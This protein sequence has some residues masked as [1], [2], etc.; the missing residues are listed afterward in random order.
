MRWPGLVMV[1]LGAFAGGSGG[2]IAVLLVG[3]AAAGWGA[4]LALPR[5]GR[6][7]PYAPVLLVALLGGALWLLSAI[8][9]PEGLALSAI[10]SLPLSLAAERLV[11]LLLAGAAWL[12][13]GLWPWRQPAMGAL[14]APIGV[15][16]V[17]RLGLPAVPA[18]MEHWRAALV[19][20]AVVGLWHA[21]ITRRLPS[22]A[23]G[24]AM[25]GT[26][27]LD[28]AGIAGAGW[29]LASAIGLELWYLVGGGAPRVAPLVRALLAV[30]AGWGTLG[31]LTGGLRTEVVYTVIAAAGAAAGLAGRR[32]SPAPRPGLR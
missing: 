22:I 32:D 19:P 23:V 7:R 8:A 3:A 9:A 21:A 12:L 4:W 28:P 10:P 13:S 25:I 1:V 2:H 20:L 27:S 17:V 31:V 16:L 26:A 14:T 11:G 18:G 24:A 5:A 29:L 15:W 30:L 6:P